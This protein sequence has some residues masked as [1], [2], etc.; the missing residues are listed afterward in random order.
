MTAHRLML[1]LQDDDAE[2]ARIAGFV[3]FDPAMAS[4]VLRLANSGAYGEAVRIANLREAVARLGTTKLVDIV[5]GD[6]L[7]RMKSNVPMYGLGEN[8]LWLHAVAALLHDIG[9][10]VMAGF[11]KA[12]VQALVARSEEQGITFVEAER[13]LFG[14]DHAEVGGALGR[15]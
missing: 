7:R 5:L 1:L 3:E 10:L 9:K 12:D 13:D 4:A 6:A 8:E 14:C 15:H 11:L 2:P